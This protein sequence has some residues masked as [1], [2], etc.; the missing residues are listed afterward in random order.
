MLIAYLHGFQANSKA[1]KASILAKTLPKV[2]DTIKFLSLDFDDDIKLAYYSLCQFIEKAKEYDEDICLVGSSM[3]GF[4]A[5]LL[6]IRYNLKVALINPCLYPSKF[7]LDNQLLGKELTNFATGAKFT[8]TQ[9]AFDFILAKEKI[10]SSYR[11]DKTLVLLQK[12]DEVLDY[13]YALEK[14]SDA[15]LV[16]VEE[17]G[18]HRYANFHTK[19]PLIVDFFKR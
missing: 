10:I 13:R 11:K 7:C 18:E 19:V 2:D 12:G 4:Q 15:A 8:I 9:D 1:Q 3:G 14:L 16:D 17:G 6:S 5:L